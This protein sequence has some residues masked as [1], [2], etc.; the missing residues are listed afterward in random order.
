MKQIALKPVMIQLPK[1]ADP[2]VVRAIQKAEEAIR[3]NNAL[4][5]HTINAIIKEITNNG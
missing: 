3:E 5:E 1:N 4:I 2:N